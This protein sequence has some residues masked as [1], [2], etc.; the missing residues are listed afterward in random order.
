MKLTPHQKKVLT[1][2]M[3]Q[4]VTTKWG[5]MC[6]YCKQHKGQ[7]SHIYPKGKYRRL[8]F[9]PDNVIPLCYAHHIH[10]WHKNPIE[11]REW[12]DSFFPKKTM[13]K[14]KM[15]T[16]SRDKWSMDYKLQK[17]YL[18]QRLALLN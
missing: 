12:L 10:F 16:L 8:E 7:M 13:E 9:E 4:C 5:E 18:E 17:L 2:L 1:S 14:L 6:L 3:Y 11:A 15:A